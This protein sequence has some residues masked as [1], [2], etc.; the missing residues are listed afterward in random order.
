MF[1]NG[2]EYFIPSDVELATYFCFSLW[3]QSL[4]HLIAHF[5]WHFD[6]TDLIIQQKLD[7]PV[8]CS[9]PLHLC[10]SLEKENA[11]LFKKIT[12]F[13]HKSYCKGM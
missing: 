12:P 8:A 6:S 3:P 9:T 4:M 5:W 11:A 1:V 10:A 13:Q 2:N 7:H